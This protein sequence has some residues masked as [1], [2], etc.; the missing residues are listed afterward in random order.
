[1]ALWSRQIQPAE[2]G[3]ERGARLSYAFV[4]L[5]GRT[6]TA[7]QLQYGRVLAFAK[8]GYQNDLSVRELERIVM[9]R[10]PIEVDLP[11]ARYFVS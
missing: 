1:M 7:R 11:K 4:L 6:S 3:V 10:R 8:I 2:S 5:V 9:C